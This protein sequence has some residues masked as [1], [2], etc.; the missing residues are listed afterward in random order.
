MA[1]TLQQINH[2]FYEILLVDLDKGI[3][4]LSDDYDGL[5]L[6]CSL[7]LFDNNDIPQNWQYY[8]SEH[9]VIL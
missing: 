6:E 4:I 3:M 9:L 5:R 2:W 7:T 8:Y 1:F